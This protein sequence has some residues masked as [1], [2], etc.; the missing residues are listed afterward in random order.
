MK[1][2]DLKIII[3]LHPSSNYKINPFKGFKTSKDKTI[4]LVKNSQFVLGHSSTAFSYSVL[5]NKP[6]FFLYS[7]KYRYS[8]I[9]D[10]KLTAKSFGKQA[11]DINNYSDEEIIKSSKLKKSFNEKYF[12]DFINSS[13]KNKNTY[14]LL[15]NYLNFEK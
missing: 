3:A 2:Y 5:Y 8:F 13:K 7:D 12:Y 11:I 1:I 4:K 10:I 14:E 15:I 9:Y 6:S